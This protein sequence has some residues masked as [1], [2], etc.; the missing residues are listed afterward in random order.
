MFD[1]FLLDDKNGDKPECIK[2][3][4]YVKKTTVGRR[5]IILLNILEL[6]CLLG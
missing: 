6:H 5:I 4:M 1:Y 2:K 3:S